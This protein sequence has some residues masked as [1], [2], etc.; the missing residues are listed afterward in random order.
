MKSTAKQIVEGFYKSNFFN[1]PELLEKY[2]HPDVELYWNAATGFSKMT[3]SDLDRMITE[4]S[5]SFISLRPSI[6]HVLQDGDQVA[7]RYTYYVR[8]IENPDEEMVIIHFIAIWE[9]K[10]G[11]MY[12]GYQISQPADEDPENLEAYKK[13]KF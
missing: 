12:R 13:I 4:M 10:D 8:T 9:L 5:K 6:T 1:D 2:V 3:Y 7:I 11:K